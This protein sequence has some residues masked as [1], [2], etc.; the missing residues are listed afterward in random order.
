MR[1]IELNV[2]K[3]DDHPSPVK[4]FDWLRH[5]KH[6]L[7]QND[8]DEMVAS[9]QALVEHIG[10][11]LDYAISQVPDRGEFINISDYCGKTLSEMD[12]NNHVLTGTMWDHNVIEALQSG[13]MSCLFKPLHGAT[14]YIY[15]DEGLREHCENNDL[16]FMEDGTQADSVFKMAA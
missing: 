12:A 1:K 13:E 14:E 4:C 2:Y 9:L 11:T 5:N 10:G 3:I 16:E 6:D 15:S 7:N 8:V